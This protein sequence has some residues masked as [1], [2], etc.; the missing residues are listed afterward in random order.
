MNQAAV[1]VLDE[2]LVVVFLVAVVSGLLRRRQS[3]FY[4]RKIV[5]NRAHKRTITFDSLESKSLT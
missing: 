1:A 5:E 2:F 4:S 3:R